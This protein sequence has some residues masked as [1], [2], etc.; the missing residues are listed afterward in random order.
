M[1]LI[2]V[3]P[4]F[5]N[6]QSAC[7]RVA[8]LSDPVDGY[9]WTGC[10]R[11]GMIRTWSRSRRGDRGGIG[12]LLFHSMDHNAALAD[13]GG[14]TVRPCVVRR[15]SG[16]RIPSPFGHIH[17]QF[18]NQSEHLNGSWNANPSEEPLGVGLPATLNARGRRVMASQWRRQRQV[19][20][21]LRR[22]CS[23]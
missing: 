23:I 5:A 19:K 21:A 22:S 10:S 17:T 18:I 2:I 11:S 4:G 16:A 15:R 14:C 13:I 7:D 8:L 12:P 20:T 3:V 6:L 1:V 9:A